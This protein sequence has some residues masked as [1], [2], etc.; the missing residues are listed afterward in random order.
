MVGWSKQGGEP[1]EMG[2]GASQSMGFVIIAVSSRLLL[3]VT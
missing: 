3:D 1:Q 2:E